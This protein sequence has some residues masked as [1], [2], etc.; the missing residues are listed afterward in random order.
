MTGICQ[1]SFRCPKLKL[2]YH[3]SALKCL[4]LIGSW[5]HCCHG[6]LAENDRY[7]GT[8]SIFKVPERNLWVFFFSLYNFDASW[9]GE[10][11]EYCCLRGLSSTCWYQHRTLD[12][13]HCKCQMQAK[14][15]A[16]IGNMHFENEISSQISSR[17]HALLT[18]NACRGCNHEV[19]HF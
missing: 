16:S 19:S 1:I 10:L 15:H 17:F 18:P 3:S 7:V 12:V 13:L 2:S 6:A 4:W 9:A 14:C 8:F 5:P 11:V